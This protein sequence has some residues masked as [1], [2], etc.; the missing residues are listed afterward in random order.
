MKEIKFYSMRDEKIQR[1]QLNLAFKNLEYVRQWF[2]D[3]QDDIKACYTDGFGWNDEIFDIQV[4]KDVFDSRASMEISL[5]MKDDELATLKIFE[6]NIKIE[7]IAETGGNPIQNIITKNG[8]IE[9]YNV[10]TSGSEL[11]FKSL[12]SLYE[13]ICLDAKDSP[14]IK[15]IAKGDAL[16]N[17][18]YEEI[19][20]FQFRD[21]L[22]I[23][24]VIERD[25]KHLDMFA[26]KYFSDGYEETVKIAK[27]V[28]MCVNF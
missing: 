25:I 16:E 17:G 10:Y 11:T 24:K 3:R 14:Y 8:D 19:P 18:G 4:F 2:I 5:R 23:Y 21:G 12:E 9:Y 27:R 28:Y 13:R 15:F 6:K 7:D 1:G 20:I 26:V 22:P